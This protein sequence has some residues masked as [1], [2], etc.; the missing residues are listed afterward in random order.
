M[1]RLRLLWLLLLVMISAPV[2]AVAGTGANLAPQEAFSLIS[3]RENLFLLD[4]R[5]FDEYRQVRLDDSRLIPIGQLTRRIAEIPRDRPILVYC[6][7]GSRSAQV[8]NYLVR[9]GYP[10]VYNLSGGIYSWAQKG[11]P[12]L[13]GGP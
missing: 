11:Y 12:I 7:V 9:N 4:V 6:A 5:T 1:K 3:Q 13:Q 8:T 2:L 10:E